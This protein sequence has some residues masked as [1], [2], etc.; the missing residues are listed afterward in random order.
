M[1]KSTITGIVIG[2]VIASAGAVIANYTA[3]KEGGNPAASESGGG[4]LSFL[5]PEP[6]YAQVLSTTPVVDTESVPREICE[7]V[8]VTEKAPVKDENQITG[9]V[10]GALIG[11]V[12]GNQVGG[13]SGKKIATVAGAVA[14]GVAGKKVQEG[15]QDKNT[16]TRLETR[17]NTV[18]DAREVI[19]GY[20]VTYKLGGKQG[21]VRMDREPGDRIPVE[22]GELQIH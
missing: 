18:Y 8:Q 2:I 17:C 4:L 14:G 6:T 22:N 9:T 11:G 1:N 19:L 10:T 20:D 21:T 13:G 7:Q 12:L 3:N 16:T 5:E 15:M